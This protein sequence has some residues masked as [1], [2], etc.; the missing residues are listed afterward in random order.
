MKYPLSPR[1][2]MIGSLILMGLFLIALIL[3]YA[4]SFFPNE[5]NRSFGICVA[6]FGFLFLVALRDLK[7]KSDNTRKINL[8]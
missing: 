6:F 4:L 1:S 7:R 5:S 2:R 8:F 3:N